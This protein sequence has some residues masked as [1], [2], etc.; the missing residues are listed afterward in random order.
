[1]SHDYKNDK[2]TDKETKVKQGDNLFLVFIEKTKQGHLP[3][4]EQAWSKGEEP[5]LL[6]L[7]TNAMPDLETLEQ[8]YL[9][10][11]LVGE[12]NFQFT[13]LQVHA[14]VSYTDIDY[15]KMASKYGMTKQ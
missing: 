14:M 13:V 7:A 6:L 3:A 9:N 8:L 4:M 10:C 1:M 11:K 2:S 12:K 15:H 5:K